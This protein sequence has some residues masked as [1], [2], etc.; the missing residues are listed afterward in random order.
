MKPPVA[1]KEDT[2]VYFGVHPDKP[3][4]DRGKEPMSPPLVLQD[5]Y[6]WMRDDDRKNPEVIAHLESENTYCTESLSRLK[7]IQN[8]LYNEMVSH[9]KET[10]EDVP[11]NSGPYIYYSKTVKGLSYKIHCRKLRAIDNN[12]SSEGKE[13]I[14]LD[15]N[16]IAEG[17]NYSV[18][19]C[20]DVSPDHK[21]LAYGV[22]NTGYETYTIRIINLETGEYLPDIIED[23]YDSIEWGNGSIFYIKM[24]KE[25]RPYELYNH[26]IPSL[27]DNKIIDDIRI[28][29]EMDSLYWM[30]ISKNHDEKYLIVDISSKETS[31]CYILDLYNIK[32][33]YEYKNHFIL[34][35]ERS[36]GIRYVIENH[37]SNLL[38]VTNKDNAK[39]NKICYVNINNNNI[40]NGNNIITTND[41]C[42][43]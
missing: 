20:F 27:N 26:I 24:D 35:S 29:Q 25:H 15:E 30:S 2:P 23:S 4:E 21:Y 41:I 12:P 16:K 28:I 10:D 34:V 22:D 1:R 7:N 3:D 5:P 43:E 40:S 11:Y 14:I 8:E 31:E 37:N 38:I 6:S 19:G 33:P 42:K 36:Y 32:D 13:E 39:T 9:M 17:Q 18:V